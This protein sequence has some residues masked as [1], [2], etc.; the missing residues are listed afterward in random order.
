MDDNYLYQ[1]FDLNAKTAVLT[2]GGGVL[3]SAMSKALA[4]VGI[5]VAVLDISPQA[6]GRVVDEIKQ[7][8][9]EAIAALAKCR[10]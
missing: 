5:K 9:G 1:Y 8:E 7:A 3:C 10:P 2:G 6:A 4:R